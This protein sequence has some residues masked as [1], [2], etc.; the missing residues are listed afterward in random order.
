MRRLEENEG[1]AIY[2][3]ATQGSAYTRWQVNEAEILRNG[4]AIHVVEG[5]YRFE[6]NFSLDSLPPGE[7]FW[8]V[9]VVDAGVDG[10]PISLWSI[11]RAI[12]RLPW[13][14]RRP[15]QPGTQEDG[16]GG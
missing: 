4:G 1:I 14:G 9:A 3:G 16:G 13:P 6:L 7:A 5:G 2:A 10:R 11:E 12:F 8:R 15:G